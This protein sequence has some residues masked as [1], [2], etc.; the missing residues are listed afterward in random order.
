M[1]LHIRASR[2]QVAERAV[3]CG[4]PARVR[5]IASML[6]GARLVNEHRGLITY[7]GN[8]KG[9]PITVATH[10]IGG[11]SA[12]LVVEELAQ[13]GVK[14]FVR[15]GTAGA[16][17]EELDAGDVVVASGAFHRSGGL[18]SQYIGEGVCASA[19]PNFE[20]TRRIVEELERRGVKH[21]VAP[22]VSNDAFY[23]E[24]EEFAKWWSSRGA[25][26]VEMEAAT[27]FAVASLRRL[28]ASAV[29]IIC[30]SLVR[31][32]GFLTAEELRP[33]VERTA[34]AVLEAL[35]RE[36]SRREGA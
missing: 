27:L 34:S 35:A 1:P 4:D 21:V 28:R 14:T 9:V 11:P 6:D 13:L 20:L 17:V 36:R 12:A 32:L 10:G 15:L 19:V 33:Y 29:L 30:D 2:D 16:L 7:T 25:V 23:A 3:I 22:V 18:F 8:Y 26:A 31:D 5:Q 24:S